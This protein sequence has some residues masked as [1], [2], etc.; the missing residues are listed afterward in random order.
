MTDEIDWVKKAEEELAHERKKQRLATH[1]DYLR[2]Y[3]VIIDDEDGGY[4]IVKDREEELPEYKAGRAYIE[5][6]L[7]RAPPDAQILWVNS[8]NVGKYV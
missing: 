3:L 4:R 8:R 2:A 1:D 6:R 7:M 5:E